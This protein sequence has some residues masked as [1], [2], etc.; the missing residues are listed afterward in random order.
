M[1]INGIVETAIHVKDVA[2]STEFCQRLFGLERIAGDDLRFCALAV[3]GNAV[4]L[5]FLEGGTGDAVSIPGGVIPG[6]DGSGHL[7]FAFKIST[8]DLESCE[9]D[10]TAAGIEIESRVNWPLGGV[11]VYFRDPDRHLVELITP[12]CWVVY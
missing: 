4:L 5:L 1:K 8:D 11:S 2:R 3:P 12:G 7:H 6:H 10:L 9:R